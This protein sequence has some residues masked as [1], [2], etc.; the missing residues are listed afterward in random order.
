MA[1]KSSG[2]V[3][4]PSLNPAADRRRMWVSLGMLAVLAV[5]AWVTIDGDAVLPVKHYSLGAL[6]SF[7]GFGISVRWLPELVIALFAFRV[8]IGNM[9]ARLEDRSRNEGLK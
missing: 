6:G 8:V 9:R 7:G 2:D 5:L 3:N 4:L 1:G